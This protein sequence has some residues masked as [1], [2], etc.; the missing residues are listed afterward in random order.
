M[1]RQL[2]KGDGQLKKLQTTLD[3][4]LEWLRSLG[5]DPKKMTFTQRVLWSSSAQHKRIK[6]FL[7]NMKEFKPTATLALTI[8]ARY[9]Y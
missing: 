1:I 6:K 5:P 8:A 2:N 7:A 4:I 9:G 3:D